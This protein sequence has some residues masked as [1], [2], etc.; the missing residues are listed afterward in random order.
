[1]RGSDRYA[2]GDFSAGA[3]SATGEYVSQNSK[4]L[5]GAGGS[6]AGMIAGAAI[7]G[8]IGLVAGAML[9]G[10]AVKSVVPEKKKLEVV[11]DSSRVPRDNYH[12]LAANSPAADLLSQGGSTGCHSRRVAAPRATSAEATWIG[13]VAAASQPAV[14]VQAHVVNRNSSSAGTP[15]NH[16]SQG[17][18]EMHIHDEERAV[19]FPPQDSFTQAV[20]NP[21]GRARCANASNSHS[22]EARQVNQPR[23]NVVYASAPNS[24]RRQ[25]EPRPTGRPTP[26]SNDTSRRNNPHQG[27][28][29]GG[30]AYRFGKF[31]FY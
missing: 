22:S 24:A 14:M 20:P 27:E 13:D 19:Y 31:S 17:Y 3:V 23:P 15:Y 7:A 5:A 8:P 11:S 12:P 29:A 9:G 2:M 25:S 21:E 26:G 1:M 10:A 16:Y 30:E 6:A 18:A 28:P 4:R